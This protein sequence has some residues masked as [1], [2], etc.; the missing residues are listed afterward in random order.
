MPHFFQALFSRDG[1]DEEKGRIAPNKRADFVLWLEQIS[2]KELLCENITGVVTAL[3]DELEEEFGGVM[4]IDIEP[5][6][7]TTH[8]LL[9]ND[10]TVL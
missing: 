6:L 7:M 1:E 10:P 5:E 2:G 9:L 8:F 3:F 4:E